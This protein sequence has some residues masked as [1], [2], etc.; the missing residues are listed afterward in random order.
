MTLH[1]RMQVM[2]DH[3]ESR[4]DLIKAA[5]EYTTQQTQPSFQRFMWHLCELCCYVQDVSYALQQMRAE[6]ERIDLS[7]QNY[8]F[9]TPL[10]NT[11][12]TAHLVL[13]AMDQTAGM[14]SPG[15][16]IKIALKHNFFIKGVHAMPNSVGSSDTAAESQSAASSTADHRLSV[17]NIVQNIDRTIKDRITSCYSQHG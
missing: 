12:Y 10:A 11:S 7:T 4:A 9:F 14:D 3:K 16:G 17:L 13:Q 15:I 8:G 2:Q 5:L 1:A 6:R